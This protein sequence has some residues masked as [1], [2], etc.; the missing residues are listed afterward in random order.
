MLTT[1]SSLLTGWSSMY[2]SVPE[3]KFHVTVTALIL[4]TGIQEQPYYGSV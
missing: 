1:V 2:Q 4:I 3:E